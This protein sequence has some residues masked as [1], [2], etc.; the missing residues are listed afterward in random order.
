[1]DT[2]KRILTA[3]VAAAIGLVPVVSACSSE[4]SSPATTAVAT[5]AAST[6]A[7][8]P[9]GAALDL[10][11]AQVGIDWHRALTIAG[12]E[13]AGKPVSVR[14]HRLIGAPQYE[15]TLVSDTQEAE[16]DIDANTGTVRGK[17]IDS[18]EKDDFPDGAEPLTTDGLVEPAVAMAT[19]TKAVPGAVSEWELKRHGDQIIYEISID[20]M[21]H[22]QEVPVDARSGQLLSID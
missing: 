2:R 21:H 6:S 16:I 8:A 1:M 11:T 12:T 7:A 5:S 15:V 3:A 19:A 22:D 10:A 13:F 20:T 9:T 4:G 14:L 18:L 17:D